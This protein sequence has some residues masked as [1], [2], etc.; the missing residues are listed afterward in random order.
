MN[1]AILA[2]N[3][4]DMMQMGHDAIYHFVCLVAI[5]ENDIDLYSLLCSVEHDTTWRDTILKHLQAK[6]KEADKVY[7]TDNEEKLSDLDWA[8]LELNDDAV[9]PEN[10]AAE[11]LHIFRGGKRELK[12]DILAIQYI[13]KTRDNSMG[14]TLKGGKDLLMVYKFILSRKPRIEEDMISVNKNSK[15]STKEKEVDNW[16]TPDD[17]AGNI[18]CGLRARRLS[19]D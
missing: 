9:N 16:Q 7:K 4:H 18:F 14:F 3:P 2:L 19:S 11:C 8:C 17:R 13:N 15:A 1:S 10:I 5:Q 12:S 6:A